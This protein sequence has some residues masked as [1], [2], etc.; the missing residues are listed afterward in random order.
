MGRRRFSIKE[1]EMIAYYR[2]Q[3]DPTSVL[4]KR[5]ICPIC[6]KSFPLEVME[7]DHIKPVSK[8][9]GDNPANLRLV[10]PRCNKKKSA[11]YRKSYTWRR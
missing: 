11:K 2:H 6:H 3:F 9:G 8:G 1:K 10:C 7:V 4:E 5:V